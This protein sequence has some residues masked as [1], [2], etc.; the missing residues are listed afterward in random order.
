MRKA[1]SILLFI[2]IFHSVSNAQDVKVTAVF[3]TSRIYIGDQTWFTIT[4]EK[5]ASCKLQIPLFRDSLMKNLQIIQGPSID[6]SLLK[7]GRVRMVQKY[8]ITSF[9]SGRYELPPVYTELKEPNGIKRFYSDYSQLEVMRVKITPPDTASKIFDI[10]KPY[11]APLTAGEVFPWV[12][13]VAVAATVIWYLI[14]YI[15]KIR[16]K[17]A[18]IEPEPVTEAA[19]VIA[20]RQLEQLKN[21]KLWEKGELKAYYTRL[22]EIARQYL[23]NRFSIYSLELTTVETLAEL[24]KAGFKEDEHYRK[25]RTVLT[26]ADLVKFAKFKPEPSENELQYNYIWEFV[27]GTRIVAETEKADAVVESNPVEK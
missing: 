16:M 4:V 27:D 17:E 10:V 8:L 9:D 6:T 2:C 13:L 21:E 11:R 14:K 12:M 23:E 22:T 18:G 5:P 15:R 19:D 25:I 26:G 3:D 24:K 20:F 1:V 7:D